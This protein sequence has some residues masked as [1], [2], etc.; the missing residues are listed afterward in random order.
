[1]KTIT[2]IAPG[3]STLL[4]YDLLTTPSPLQVSPQSGNPSVSVLT[5]V[6]SCPVNVGQATVTSITFNLPVGDPANPDAASLT[7]T[8]S[9]LSP[10]VSSSGTDVWL[11]GD[12]GAAG[13]FVLKPAPGNNGTISSQGL[14]VTI[15]GLVVNLVVGTAL[16]HV[17]EQAMADNAPLQPRTADV[18]VP[19]FPQNV[20]VQYLTASEPM[21]QNGQSVTLS[22]AGSN[23]AE[24]LLVYGAEPPIDVS[25]IRIW[26]SPRLSMTTTF[27]LQVSAQ[28]GGQTVNFYFGVTVIVSNPDI[29]AQSLDVTG[30]TMLQGTVNACSTLAVVGTI[31]GFGVVPVATV[32]A[33]GGDVVANGNALAAQGWLLCDGSAVSRATYPVLFAAV[34]TRHG[35]G[36]GSTTF[37]LPD[38]RGR[39]LRGTSYASGRDPDIALRVAAAP[40]GVAG[41]GTGSVQP[42]ATALAAT[43]AMTTD[44]Q[45]NHTHS[46]ANVPTDNSSYRI[47]GSSLSKWNDGSVSTSSAGAHTHTVT[48]G[49]DHETRP[50]NAYV[51]FLIRAV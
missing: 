40:G 16:V 49:G 7:D 4:T 1:M 5:F 44:S 25:N 46:V 30:N 12:G 10:S 26:A 8:T 21:V 50:I 15:E 2:Q 42:G 14:T 48:S 43:A 39:F 34:G 41:N 13:S 51:D 22:W 17:V 29:V 47:A 6:V 38:Y 9:G 33:Y 19:K 20:S 3:G 31:S 23:G 24:Y 27:I 28:Q 18:L 11:I 36:D 37:N 32:I 45:G 35:A